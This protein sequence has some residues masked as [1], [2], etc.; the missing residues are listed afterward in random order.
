VVGPRAGGVDGAGGLLLD[1][2]T[3]GYRGGLGHGRRRDAVVL[4]DLRLSAAP[5]RVTVLLGP[6]G[7]GKSTLLRTVACLQPALAG[8][9]LIDGADLLHLPARARARQLAVVLTERFDPGLLTGGEVVALGRHPYIGASGALSPGD[10]QAVDEALAVMHAHDLA[11]VR[12][13]ELSDGQR[14]RIMVARALAQQPRLLVLDEP[15]AFLDAP[16]RIELLDRLRGIAADRAIAV[17]LSTHDVEMALRAG[18]DAW[19]ITRRPDR[20]AGRPDPDAGPSRRGAGRSGRDA[21]RSGRGAAAVVSG[22]IEYLAATGAINDAFDT[23]AVGFDPAAGT[24]R[25][26]SS[27]AR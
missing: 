14:Q 1:G 15:T 13:A 20:D 23:V 7:A 24:F 11:A 2:L 18:G 27:G 12:V 6:N 26:R 5:G 19:L 17:V 10:R 3:V 4:S 22:Q 25:L 16:A 21:G 9:V 8:R